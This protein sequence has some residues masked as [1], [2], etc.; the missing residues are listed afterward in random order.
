MSVPL[1]VRAIAR[2]QVTVEVDAAAWGG[3]CSIGQL[4]KQAAEDAVSQI[5]CAC[6]SSGQRFRLVGTK[7]LGVITEERQ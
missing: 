1:K 6:N 3:D 2:V 5:R 4:Y 7:V